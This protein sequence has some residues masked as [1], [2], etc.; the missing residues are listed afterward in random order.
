[1]GLGRAELVGLIPEA[2]LAGL[3]ATTSPAFPAAPP[4]SSRTWPA[5]G[6][7][8]LLRQI[9][10]VPDSAAPTR[11][12]LCRHAVPDNPGHV[13]Y[14]HLPGFGLGDLGRRQA[15]GLGTFLAGYPVRRIYSSPLDRALETATLAASRLPRAPEIEIRPDLLEAEWGKRI[16]GVPQSQVLFRRPQFI[17]HVIRPGA[18]AGDETVPAMAARIHRV[19]Q[20]AVAAAPGA[21]AV[22]V[23]HADPIKAFWN[24]HLR[25]ADWRFHFLELPKGGFLEL[26]YDRAGRLRRL[27]TH[28]PLDDHGVPG[29]TAPATHPGGGG[30]GVT[31]TGLVVGAFG[32]G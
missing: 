18:L 2:A 11:I 19:V 13:F 4:P 1:M 8:S 15:L 16:Q 17:M 12:F 23:S 21:A 9:L 24:R 31:D 22:I 26:E 10:R 3:G 32:W 7:G 14:G 5:R 20:E 29:A 6:W 30:L 27:T 25:R 28:P